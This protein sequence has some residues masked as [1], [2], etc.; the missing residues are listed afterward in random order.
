MTPVL[1]RWDLAEKMLQSVDHHVDRLLVV[2]NSLGTSSHAMTVPE[3]FA[4]VDRFTPPYMG[5]GYGGAINF[6]ITQTPE[7]PWWMWASNDV[8]FEPGY[9]DTVV[10]RMDAATRPTIITQGFTWA[11]VNRELIDLV[12]L[13]DD[14][15]FYPIY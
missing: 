8:V 12:G 5:L 4:C 3:K 14:W 13:I 7:L 15:S 10:A 1:N 6:M 11:A 9:L 2:D